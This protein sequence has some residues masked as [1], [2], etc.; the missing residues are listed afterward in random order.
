MSDPPPGAPGRS[1]TAE[2]PAAG[3][4][5]L[6]VGHGGLPP[7]PQRVF[8]AAGQGQPVA[9]EERVNGEVIRTGEVTPFAHFQELR[10]RPLPGHLRSKGS[11][12]PPNH[13]PEAPPAAA[14]PPAGGAFRNADS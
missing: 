14:R 13:P 8:G 9:F 12:P 5:F 10:P 7:E 11:V 4:A 6:Y 1:G 2:P 3:S